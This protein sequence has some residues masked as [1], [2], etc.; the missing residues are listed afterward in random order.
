M[1]AALTSFLDTA[2]LRFSHWVSGH[3]RDSSHSPDAFR[4]GTVLMA[5][6]GYAVVWAALLLGLAAVA[7]V[8]S[9]WLDGQRV[10][11]TMVM[12]GLAGLSLALSV[13]RALW[14]P[15]PAPKGRRVTR[16]QAPALFKMLDKVRERT[17][18]PRFDEVLIDGQLNAAVVQRP[19]LG[20]LGWYRN[21]LVL[22]L[23]LILLLNPRQLASVVA[24]EYGHLSGSHGKLGAWVYR[25]RR[26][27]LR[28][29]ELR[30]NASGRGGSVADVVLALF[31]ASYFPRF[32]ARAFVLSR[33]Q[34]YE[35]DKVAHEV[36]GE[37]ASAQALVALHVADRYLRDVFWPEVFSRARQGGD[38]RQTP[39]RELRSKLALSLTHPQAA[40]WL[41]EAYKQLPSSTDSHPSLRQ[42]LDLANFRPE[43]PGHAPDKSSASLLG[44]AMEVVLASLD[45]QWQRDH[46]AQWAQTA[47]SIAARAARLAALDEKRETGR[48]TADEAEDRAACVEATQGT[49]EALPAWRAAHQEFPQ[50]AGIAYGLARLMDDDS[51]PEGQARAFALWELVAQ[52]DHAHA[53]HALE[54]CIASLERQGRHAEAPAWRQRLKDRLQLE[55]QAGQERVDFSSKPFFSS[56]DLS[57]PQIQDCLDVLIRERAVGAAYLVRKQT[58]LFPQRPF[59]V[60][61][62]ERSRAPK[63]PPSSH[64]W[65]RLEA[66]LSLPGEFM[67]IDS[68]HPYWRD[69]DHEPVLQQIKRVGDARIYGGS[70]LGGR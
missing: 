50:H 36:S 1:E 11:G 27:W 68:A 8:V 4:R 57:R 20:L 64:Y 59:Y 10:G 22:G 49:E 12:V 26:S 35:A 69:S 30:E 33:Q 54:Q 48:L 7:W 3:E 19:R 55:E 24:H 45:T 18:G 16:A 61:M 52:S 53:V 6:L 17:K 5:L 15:F 29:A 39:Y 9:R 63:Q 66:K 25:T 62:V 14:T 37:Q 31:F 23:P 2:G 67:V 44:K 51:S 40:A 13:M 43:L 56:A 32:N 38:L 47:R 34:E 70:A 46:A 28:L 21:T 58:R 60:L 41:S 42:R 65:Q